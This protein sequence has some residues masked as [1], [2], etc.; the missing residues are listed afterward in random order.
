MELKTKAPILTQLRALTRE[1]FEDLPKLAAQA[2]VAIAPGLKISLLIPAREAEIGLEQ[3]VEKAHRF[4]SLLLERNPDNTFEIILIP[5]PAPYTDEMEVMKTLLRFEHLASR[6]PGT[7]IVTHLSPPDIPGKGS[8][9]RSGFVASRGRLICFTDSDLP[10]DLDFFEQ[11]FVRVAQ[12]YDLVTGNRRMSESRFDIPVSVLPFAYNRHRL[13]LLFNRVVRTLIPVGTTDTQAGIKVLSRRLAEKAFGVQRCPGFFFD[14]EIFL[15]NRASGWAQAEIPVSL[16]LNSEKSTVRIIRESV[17]AFYWLGRIT[18]GNKQG[19]YGKKAKS[20]RVLKQYFRIKKI[21]AVTRIF[22]FLR[23][24]L[25]PYASMAKHLPPAGKIID[26]GCGHGLFGISLA[27]KSAERQVL[28]VD[29]DQKRIEIAREASKNLKNLHFAS[30]ALF[31]SK[32]DMAKGISLIDVMHYF[33]AD[34]QRAHLTSAFQQLDQNGV[35]IFREVDP[36]AGL[37][38]VVN[39]LYEK[40]AT[41]VGFTRSNEEKLYFRKKEEWLKLLTEIGFRARAERCSSILFAD[42]LFIGEKP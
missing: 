36:E 9:L 2:K 39:R 12:G 37:I 41:R 17:L 24:C 16:H 20:P 32:N 35:L 4:L 40:I 21:P 6:F 15:V 33:D 1:D 42:V 25:T 18:L 30:S 22:L 38:S 34:T 31:D 8:A 23:W 28:G 5:N 27:Q 19:H 11:A 29:H 10:Y 26:Y 14:L 7:R 13:G 3:T